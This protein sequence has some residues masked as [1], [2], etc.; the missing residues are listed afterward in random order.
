MRRI[1]TVILLSI[2]V[3]GSAA[4]AHGGGAE[5]MPHTN[6]TDLPPYHPAPLCHSKRSCLHPRHHHQSLLI[7]RH[8][9]P[10]A[11]VR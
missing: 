11:P 3:Y 6:F 1:F 9:T 10:G 8:A 5:S 2:L 4:Y 7:D